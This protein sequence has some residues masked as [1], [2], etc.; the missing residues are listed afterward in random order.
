MQI[1]RETDY[2]IRCVCYLAQRPAEIVP[3]EEISNG[4]AVPRDFMAKILQKLGRASI[5]RSHRGANGGFELARRPS[6]ISF[7]DVIEAVQGPV[8][9]NICAL[10]KRLCSRSD[11]C[12]V[13]PV[14]IDVREQVRKVLAKNS[15]AK[16]ISKSKNGGLVR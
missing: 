8:A 11:S 3:V 13:H 5:V 16:F 6:V 7:L 15:F 9:M 12:I 1:T 2:A 4:T 14:W 10:D